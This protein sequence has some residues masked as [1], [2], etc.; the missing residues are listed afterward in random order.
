MKKVIVLSILLMFAFIIKAQT[1]KG[2]REICL[3][4]DYNGPNYVKEHRNYYIK[5]CCEGPIKITIKFTG[6]KS[7]STKKKKLQSLQT[8]HVVTT[9]YI[10]EI[11]AD[12]LPQKK[13]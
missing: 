13:R 1:T 11:Y 3:K 4:I 8:F 5:N 2:P 7:G 10:V 12:E 9:E 6:G